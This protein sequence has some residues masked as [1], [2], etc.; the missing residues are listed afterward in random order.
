MPTVTKKKTQRGNVSTKVM[1]KAA[2]LVNEEGLSLREAAETF[3]IPCH[4]TLYRFAKKLKQG[5]PAKV[6][7]NPKKKVFLAE[8]EELII[9]YA[10]D[11]A[12][13]SFGFGPKG[14]RKLAFQLAVKYDLDHPAEW[15]AS[16]SLTSY[17]FKS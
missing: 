14:I 1:T 7:Y 17:S 13:H 9:Q 16:K 10:V 8:Q 12:N 6:G 3:Q 15:K 5:L 4:V 11:A 2:Q